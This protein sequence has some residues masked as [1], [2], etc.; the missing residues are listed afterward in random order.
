MP[1][2]LITWIDIFKDILDRYLTKEERDNLIRDNS[3]KKLN[4]KLKIIQ[5]RKLHAQM[6][7]LINSTQRLGNNIKTITKSTRKQKRNEHLLTLFYVSQHT[8]LIIQSLQENYM[9]LSVMNMNTC[10]NNKIWAIWIHHA[11]LVQYF[12]KAHF[13]LG[14]WIVTEM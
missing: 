11:K 12:F 7:S 9:L 1:I 10:K 14:F 13:Y 3:I 4:L 8:I 2:K 5:Q 6:F